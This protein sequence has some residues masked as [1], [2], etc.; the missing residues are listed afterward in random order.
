MKINRSGITFLEIIF[1]LG[2]SVAIIFVVSQFAGTISGLEN[3]INQQLTA[4]QDLAQVLQ[5]MTTEVRSA[6]PSEIGAY[7]I[8]AASSSSF[9]FY[10]DIDRD[11]LNDRVR[12][13]FG[14]STLERGIVKPT[15][16]P[17]VYTTSTEVVVP[18]VMAVDI[19][20]SSFY[21][22]GESA[23]STDAPLADPITLS[24][25]RFIKVLVTASVDASSTQT[26]S[27]SQTITLRN[28][29]GN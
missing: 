19:A 18:L 28:L 15:G 27:Y 24:D 13:F 4:Q 22:F 1:A 16:T 20:S 21:Y 8:A 7:P 10:S 23:T 29:R 5:V 11:G 9:I 12:Y 14:T 6:A 26:A 3:L 25:I 17:V 2:M